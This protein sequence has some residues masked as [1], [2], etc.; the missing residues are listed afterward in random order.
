M[1]ATSTS[2]EVDRP[3]SEVFAYVTSPGHFSEWQNGVVEGHR[4][5]DGFA[6]IG[7]RC[8]NTSQIGFAKGSVTCEITGIDLPTRGP[9]ALQPVA[10]GMGNLPGPPKPALCQQCSLPSVPVVALGEVA[11]L[12]AR[13][14][15]PAGAGRR[16]PM[17]RRSSR[18][19]WKATRQETTSAT[20]G[21]SQ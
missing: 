1:T 14:G 9:S 15:V 18:T 8:V 10:R 3:A 21:S 16:A 6:S 11:S 20:A 7:D 4:Q 12:P 2:V 5:G 13:A 19:A 17:T